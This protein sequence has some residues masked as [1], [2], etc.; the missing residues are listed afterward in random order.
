M[1]LIP[2]TRRL[3]AIGAA[4]LAAVVQVLLT[5]S[6][7]FNSIVFTSLTAPTA[8][9]A[10]VGILMRKRS[11]TEW[12]LGIALV[13]CFL[14]AVTS[15]IAAVFAPEFWIPVWAQV[16][17]V[18]LLGVAWWLRSPDFEEDG[19]AWNREFLARER[20]A[21]PEWTHRRSGMDPRWEELRRV[22]G[23]RADPFEE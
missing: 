12:P 4:G 17:V 6:L 10:A 9:V 21:H 16:D 20:A 19:S 13:A 22:R 1:R 14:N 7:P 3:L 23:E 2:R 11:T 15:G 8:A 18:I 5:T